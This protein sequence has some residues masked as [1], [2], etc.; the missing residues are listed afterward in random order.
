MT[1]TPEAL[2]TAAIDDMLLLINRVRA[3][4]PRHP[5]RRLEDLLLDMRWQQALD[6]VQP[7]HFTTAEGH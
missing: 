2:A 5:M 6:L 4:K 3:E 7:Q 1:V